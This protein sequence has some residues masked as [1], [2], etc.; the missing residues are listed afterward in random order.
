MTKAKFL[1]IFFLLLTGV[2]C[3]CGYAFKGEAMRAAPVPVLEVTGTFESIDE[4]EEPHRIVLKVNGDE[5]S[6]P[7]EETCVFLDDRG[8]TVERDLFVRRYLRRVI[9]VE[10][11]EDTGVVILCRVG[12]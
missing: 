1:S 10:L 6:G 9:T 12:S 7:L 4:T 11:T 2:F 5:V 3:F 8:N